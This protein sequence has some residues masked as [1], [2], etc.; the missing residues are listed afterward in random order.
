MPKLQPKKGKKTQTESRFDTRTGFLCIVTQIKVELN[1]SVWVV[2]NFSMNRV[3]PIPCFGKPSSESQG[4]HV[5]KGVG[6]RS[7]TVASF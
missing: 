3:S 4:I 6:L 5:M 7:E 2:L 1:W